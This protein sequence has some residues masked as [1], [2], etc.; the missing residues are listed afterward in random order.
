[1][2][3]NEYLRDFYDGRQY[4]E[5]LLGSAD[6]EDGGEAEINL[7]KQGV[8]LSLREVFFGLLCMSWANFTRL[9]YCYVHLDGKI[10]YL[11]RDSIPGIKMTLF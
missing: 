4:K 3:D 11:I 6:R 5:L 1:M 8:K 10:G 7:R 2:E 9:L